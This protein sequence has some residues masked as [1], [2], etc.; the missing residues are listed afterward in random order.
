MNF[1]GFFRFKVALILVYITFKMF[2]LN[3]VLRIWR[4]YYNK[5][6]LVIVND[7]NF[8]NTSLIIFLKFRQIGW[9]FNVSDKG[10]YVFGNNA[11]F[12][13]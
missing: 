13:Y 7:Y 9:F 1:L 8:H 10:Y 4:I 5:I 12:E 2:H 3:L 6:N 11:S